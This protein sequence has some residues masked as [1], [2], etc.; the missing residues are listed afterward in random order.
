VAPDDYD[1]SFGAGL[2]NADGSFLGVYDPREWIAGGP[3]AIGDLNGDGKQ[4]VVTGLGVLLGNGDG[5]VGSLTDVFG[6]RHLDPMVLADVDADGRLDLLSAGVLLLGRG[7]GTFGDASEIATGGGPP[8][9]SM[10]GIAVRDLNGDGRPDMVVANYSANAVTVLLNGIH[11]PVAVED[12]QAVRSEGRIRLGWSLSVEARQNLMGLQVRRAMNSAGPYTVLGL[13]LLEPAPTMSF[14]DPDVFPDREYWYQIVLVSHEG[15]PAIT[16]SL[17]VPSSMPSPGGSVL[18]QPFVPTDGGPI[19][20][21][22]TVTGSRTDVRLT[23]FD[24]LGHEI[25]ILDRG[26]REQGDYVRTW[27]R[28]ATSGLSVPRGVYLVQLNAGGATATRKLVLLRR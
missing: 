8:A 12:L 15:T 13:G 10:G 2:G 17:R 16:A 18:R 9:E 27:D 14:V 28:Y 5:T 19:Q 3:V 23:I 20:V 4:D 11:V 6:G 7:D 26:V 1:G 25:R 21:Q 24:V 22:Y